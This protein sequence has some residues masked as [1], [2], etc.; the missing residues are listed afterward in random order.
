MKNAFLQDRI[1]ISFTIVV[2]ITNGVL[3]GTIL[4]LKNSQMLHPK[5]FTF[6]TIT[7]LGVAFCQCLPL[8]KPALQKH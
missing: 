2:Y 3:K 6:N 4:V 7:Q 1:N 8:S 5:T